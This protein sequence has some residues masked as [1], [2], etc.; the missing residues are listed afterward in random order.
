MSGLSDFLTHSNAAPWWGATT[1]G[2][3]GTVWGGVFLE[4]VKNRN[5]IASEVR[6]AQRDQEAQT[7]QEVQELGSKLLADAAMLQLKAA[8]WL[9]HQ[10]ANL[11]RKLENAIEANPPRSVE[12]AQALLT[13]LTPP[14]PVS[15]ATMEGLLPAVSD[16]SGIFQLILV[17]YSEI[18]VRL[19]HELVEL[20]KPLVE[21][22]CKLA[23]PSIGR[24][25]QMAP[26]HEE[27][28]AAT[29]AFA[30]GMRA[31]LKEFEPLLRPVALSPSEPTEPAAGS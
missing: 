25:D 28:S 1:L 9:A 16:L 14:A 7:R 12:E 8:E 19:P 10:G 11:M 6:K 21:S 13:S 17:T 18:A 24:E 30:N 5:L 27:Y 26:I 22:A 29:F 2:I 3:A 15:T 4:R 31:Y 23:T 20:A